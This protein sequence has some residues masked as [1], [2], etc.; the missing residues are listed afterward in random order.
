MVQ[1]KANHVEILERNES[2]KMENFSSTEFATI[3]TGEKYAAMKYVCVCLFAV[4]MRN[5]F[6]F[7]RIHHYYQHQH[8][9]H[10]GWQNK[11]KIC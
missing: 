6:W 2:E 8:Q 7:K 10:G 5:A 3:T 1:S 11:Y 4:D 9:H